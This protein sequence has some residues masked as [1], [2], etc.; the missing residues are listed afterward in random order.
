LKFETLGGWGSSCTAAASKFGV[1]R[2]RR[3]FVSH[4]NGMEI[5]EIHAYPHHKPPDLL[6]IGGQDCKTRQKKSLLYLPPSARK[7]E[8]KICRSMDGRIPIRYD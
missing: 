4:E 2:N 6:V 8:T 1:K 3:G 7:K 5:C